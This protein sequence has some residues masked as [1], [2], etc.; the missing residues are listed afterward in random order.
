MTKNKVIWLVCALLAGCAQQ[1]D[2]GRWL[3]DLRSET[4][5]RAE[6][7]L[8]M[9]FPQ[10]QMALFKHEAA[11][12]SAPEFALEPG[13]TGYATLV[14]RPDGVQ[15]D[16]RVILAD[17]MYYRASDLGGWMAK[18][19]DREYR[20]RAKVYS[21][22]TDSQL[23]A[24]IDQMFNAVTHPGACAGPDT[25]TPATADGDAAGAK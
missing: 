7:V 2:A 24:R 13:Q 12:G 19:G 3:Q 5:F 9:T 22:Y 18:D 23:D 8:P 14:L 16:K 17:L 1:P 15:D 10:I 4:Y 6:R 20:T 25:D 11:C 21:F